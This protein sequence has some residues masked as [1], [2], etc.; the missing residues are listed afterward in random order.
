V[1]FPQIILIMTRDSLYAKTQSAL[2]QIQARK[3]Q[4]IIIANESDVSLASDVSVSL[5]VH[6]QFTT[7]RRS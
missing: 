2:Q 4:P 5:S 3:G 6:F 1:V 7:T